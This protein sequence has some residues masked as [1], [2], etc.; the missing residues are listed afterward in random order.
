MDPD[1]WGI[2]VGDF[3]GFQWFFWGVQQEVHEI[4]DSMGIK[5]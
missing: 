5:I 4:G 1:F 3:M 2:F